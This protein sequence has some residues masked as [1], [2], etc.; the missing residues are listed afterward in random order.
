MTTMASCARTV[1]LL[2]GLF[3]KASVCLA[4]EEF[5]IGIIGSATKTPHDDSALR[6]AISETD[7]ENLAFVVVNGIKSAQETCS[8]NV[9]LNRKNLFNAAKN[10]L[11]VSLAASDWTDC[12]TIAGKSSAIERLSR[13]RELFFADDFSFGASKIPLA[14]QSAAAKFRSYAENARWELGPVLFA[15]INLPSDNNHYL[16]AGGRNSEFEDRS[17]ANLNWLQ[18]V[19]GHATIRKLDAVVLFCDHD[20]LTPAQSNKQRDGFA[21]IREDIVRVAARFSGRILMV[22]S[23]PMPTTGSPAGISWQGNLGTLAVPTGWLRLKISPNSPALFS[24]I[25]NESSETQRTTNKK[26]AALK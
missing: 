5:S 16:S 3:L 18:R 23:G 12:K 10:G 8:D 24:V 1:L 6:Q 22:H 4:A 2:I 15:T 25:S 13:L 21:E 11:V 26:T 7:D 17:V 14:R 19:V 20:P 9:Y